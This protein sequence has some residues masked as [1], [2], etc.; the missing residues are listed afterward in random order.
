MKLAENMKIVPILAS[1][2]TGAGVSMDSINMKDFHHATFLIT[3]ATLVGDAVLTVNSGAT[4]G[5]LTSALTF[6]YALGGADIGTAVAGSTSSADVLA[7]DTAAA[8]LTLTAATYSDRLLVIEVDASA[9]DVANGEE[10]LTVALSSAG[11]SGFVHCVAVLEPRY[12]G[13]RSVTCLA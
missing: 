6:N 1:E 5:A 10:W 2:D 3:F 4:A 9:M 8:T 13:S 12:S 7:A 11:T